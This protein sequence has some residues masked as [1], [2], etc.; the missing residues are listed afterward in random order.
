MAADRQKILHT[1]A[2]GRRI[3]MNLDRDT[4][5]WSAEEVSQGYH[6]FHDEFWGK[7]ETSE[8]SEVNS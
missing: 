3:K 6:Q 1:L 5:E 7:V 4:S 2:V 8:Q